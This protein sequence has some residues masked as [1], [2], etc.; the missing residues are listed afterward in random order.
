[1]VRKSYNQC[2]STFV[3]SSFAVIG[4]K[5]NS[6]QT[7]TDSTQVTSVYGVIVSSFGCHVDG[8]EFASRSDR[9]FFSNS[10]RLFMVTFLGW[11]TTS[12][13][14]FFRCAWLLH[15]LP[16]LCVKWHSKLQMGYMEWKRCLSYPYYICKSSCIYQLC[17]FCSKAR[18][19]HTAIKFFSFFKFSFLNS[20]V[21]ESIHT[22]SMCT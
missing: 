1:M 9:F 14:H 2:Q 16:V 3:C 15:I 22:R 10:V 17:Y 19:R 4:S 5:R 7:K 6:K 8:R 21:K 20:H 13:F 12:I 11:S 18:T